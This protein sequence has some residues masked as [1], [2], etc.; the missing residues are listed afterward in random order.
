MKQIWKKRLNNV[1]LFVLAIMLVIMGV[2]VP[3]YGALAKVRAAQEEPVAIMDVADNSG[4][5][6]MLYV[7]QDTVL[8][9]RASENAKIVTELPYGC[10]VIY[11]EG[12]DEWSKVRTGEFTGYVKSA[13]LQK[14][15]PNEELHEEMEN[16]ETYDAEFV[17]EVE[18]LMAEKRESRIFG[19]IIV[20]LIVAIFGIG[21]FST[22]RKKKK[23]EGEKEE[24]G[25]A[26]QVEPAKDTL[27]YLDEEH[28]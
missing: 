11:I 7:N 26:E 17:N 21:I 10:L 22:V 3:E 8:Y 20:V 19:A 12:N 27:E 6:Q 25:D 15:S 16:L 4:A 2:V 28:K 13:L 18:R 23:A 14:E 5:M 1:G 9:E 24:A